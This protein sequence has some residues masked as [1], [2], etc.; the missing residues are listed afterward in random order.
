MIVLSANW[1]RFDLPRIQSAIDD[2]RKLKQPVTLI[3]PIMRYDVP[4]RRLLADEV[5]H[6]DPTLAERH[7][8]LAFDDLDRDM[9]AKAQQQWHVPYFSFRVF[10]PDGHCREWSRKDVPLQWDET[11]LTDDGS[12]LVAQAMRASGAIQLNRSKLSN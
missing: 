3:G 5:Q 12:I 1:Q 4:L 9:A 6:N 7:R 10:C 8:V 11:H 2:L